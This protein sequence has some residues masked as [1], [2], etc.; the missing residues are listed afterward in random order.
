MIKLK[1]EDNESQFSYPEDV[2]R[3][4]AVMGDGT[5]R[6]APNA[7]VMPAMPSKTPNC[8]RK[9]TNRSSFHSSATVT[10]LASRIEVHVA[11]AAPMAP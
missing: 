2:G 3:I 4:V 6:A 9:V 8:K 5:I 11:V 7:S 10:N 1:R